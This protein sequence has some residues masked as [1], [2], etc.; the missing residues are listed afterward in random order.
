MRRIK[1]IK[2][3]CIKAL[4]GLLLSGTVISSYSQEIP[5]SFS[6]ADT[7]VMYLPEGAPD[8]LLLDSLSIVNSSMDSVLD[9]LTSRLI[10]YKALMVAMW[11]EK[12]TINVRVFGTV[13]NYLFEDWAINNTYGYL[14][15]NGK[16]VYV[17]DDKDIDMDAYF[18]KMSLPICIHWKVIKKKPEEFA[19]FEEEPQWWYILQNGNM[20]FTNS[21]FTEGHLLPEKKPSR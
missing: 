11:K 14:T 18:K 19:V 3:S 2:K 6:P 9:N 1:C 5:E 16:R 15:L 21:A 13:S 17:L 8:K 10:G 4:L 20:I 7:L 12:D